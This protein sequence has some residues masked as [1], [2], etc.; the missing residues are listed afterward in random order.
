MSS[1]TSIYQLVMFSWGLTKGKRCGSLGRVGL[2]LAFIWVRERAVVVGDQAS[3]REAVRDWEEGTSVVE[4]LGEI[5][6]GISLGGGESRCCGR[7]RL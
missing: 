7:Q 1:Y 2:L 6:C 5:V 3:G 4:R